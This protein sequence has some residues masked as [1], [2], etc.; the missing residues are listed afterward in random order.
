MFSW[1]K[2]KKDAIAIKLFRAKVQAGGMTKGST[3]NPDFGVQH[4]EWVREANQ[5]Q[6]SAMNKKIIEDIEK[7]QK[8]AMERRMK[9]V[10]KS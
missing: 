4:P 7:Q 10:G 6:F 1:E 9:T 3:P 5:G 8:K 2:A